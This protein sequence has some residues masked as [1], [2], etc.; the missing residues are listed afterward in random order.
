MHSTRA[1]AHDCASYESRAF[2]AERERELHAKYLA[3]TNALT[4][5]QRKTEERAN[6]LEELIA[7]REARISAPDNDE[8]DEELYINH[9]L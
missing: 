7:L 9:K 2:G 5:L 4:K 1:S 3:R 6:L 8:D